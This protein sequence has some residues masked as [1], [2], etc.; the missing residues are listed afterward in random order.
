[1]VKIKTFIC[2]TNPIV[3]NAMV[4]SRRF[5]QMFIDWSAVQDQEFGRRFPER[6]VLIAAAALRH[7]PTEASHRSVRPPPA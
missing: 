6:P 7:L 4:V 5:V 3:A 1:M 2:C